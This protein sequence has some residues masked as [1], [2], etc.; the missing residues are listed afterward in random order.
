MKSSLENQEFERS[1]VSAS[2]PVSSDCT[3]VWGYVVVQKK[4]ETHILV[5]A[6]RE[7]WRRHKRKKEALA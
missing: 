5:N 3:T 1:F 6:L 4:Q 7:Q 2:I